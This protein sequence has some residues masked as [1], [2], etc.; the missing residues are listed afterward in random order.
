MLLWTFGLEYK[1]HRT[2]QWE[3]NVSW[4]KNIIC[5]M[6]CKNVAVQKINHSINNSNSAFNIRLN[7][8]SASFNHLE[9]SEYSELTY[10]ITH[11]L[12]NWYIW[13]TTT[14]CWGICWGIWPFMGPVA[15]VCD[16]VIFC[17]N[18]RANFNF[19]I[20]ILIFTPGPYVLETQN[21]KR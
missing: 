8:G 18:I 4:L 13:N 12:I 3:H 15:D 10:H 21:T 14:S 5:G 2:L 17:I 7:I 16:D 19:K 1:T 11:W 20:R 6:R 9:W